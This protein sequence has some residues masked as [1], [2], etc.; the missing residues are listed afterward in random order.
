MIEIELG[1]ARV[2]IQGS[3]DGEALRQVLAHVGRPR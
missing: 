3:V 2:R 1:R